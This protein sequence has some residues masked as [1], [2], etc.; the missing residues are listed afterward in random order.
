M[1]ADS[2]FVQ[3]KTHEV[4]EDYALSG[5]NYVILSD[6]CSNGGGPRIDSDFG[7]RLLAKAAEQHLDKQEKGYDLFSHAVDITAQAQRVSFPNLNPKCLTATLLTLR[8]VDNCLKFYMTGDG[9]FGIRKKDGTWIIHNYEFDDN[10]PLYLKYLVSKNEKDDYFNKRKGTLTRTT[11]E[12]P[13]IERIINPDITEQKFY[14]LNESLN[15]FF[16][17]E[18]PGIDPFGCFVW[19]YPSEDVD[20][21]FICSDGVSSFYENIVTATSKHKEDVDTTNVLSAL[22]DFVTFRP[23]FLRLQRKWLYSR[24]GTFVKRNWENADDVSVGVLKL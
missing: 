12:G 9:V 20:F 3:G 13:S 21:A 14:D 18:N 23:G 11:Y 24:K 19:S 2:I 17:G 4:C 1:I 16:F 22:L 7:A 6:G 5:N 8:L 15:G 10:A